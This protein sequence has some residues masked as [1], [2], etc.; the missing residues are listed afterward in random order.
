M[1]FSNDFGGHTY[2]LTAS[3]IKFHDRV[4][5]NRDAAKRDMY[6]YM[7]RKGLALQDVYDD[8]HYKTYICTNGVRFYINR[9]DYQKQK[10]C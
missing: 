3:G 8:N 9:Q 10:T 1:F 7:S 4:Y 2:S 6:E 5:G